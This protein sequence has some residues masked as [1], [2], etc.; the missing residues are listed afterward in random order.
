M[1]ET[2]KFL[3]YLGIPYSALQSIIFGLMLLSFPLGA[4]L[5]FNSEIGKELNFDFPLNDVN[6]FIAG[7][8]FQAPVNVE[9]GDIFI[10]IW[11]I[12][13][14]LFVISFLGP[15]KTFFQ[16][17]S[18]LMSEGRYSTEK[19]YLVFIIKWFSIIILVS[20]AVIGIQDYFGVPTTP[21]QA[22]NRLIQFL[23]ISIAPITE[24]LGFRVLL[25]GLPLFLIYSQRASIREFL[26]TLWQPKDELQIKSSRK[27]LLLILIVGIFFG[28]AHIISGE[29]WSI[30]K[31]AQASISGIIIGWVYYNHGLISAIL[32]HWATNYFVIS[33]VFLLSEV[34]EISVE[35]AFSHSLINTLEII[36]V[37]T[38]VLSAIVL[39]L[40][41]CIQKNESRKLELNDEI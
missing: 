25:I 22:D 16:F 20:W 23:E 5:V 21:P 29:P 12:F 14:S 10:I 26:K 41:Y 27:P 38:G 7:I 17:L 39:F 9:V 33:Y 2:E 1:I 24:E 28:L 6:F 34:N 36:F 4:I 30:G 35:S 8:N 18:P 19:N 15:K 40:N 37:I 11:I 13:M 31:F 3:Q 32:V